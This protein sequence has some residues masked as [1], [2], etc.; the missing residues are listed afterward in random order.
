VEPFARNLYDAG[1]VFLGLR[2]PPRCAERD[3]TRNSEARRP[4][5]WEETRHAGARAARETRA[6]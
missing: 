2:V 5:E 3:R 6:F 1:V 4:G